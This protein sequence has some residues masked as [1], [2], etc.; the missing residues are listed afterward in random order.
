ML[1]RGPKLTSTR[2]AVLA[3]LA[4]MLEGRH[5]DCESLIGRFL[6]DPEYQQA[7]KILSNA[8]QVESYRRLARR[9][10]IPSPPGWLLPA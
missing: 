5:P 1:Q 4:L 3:E 9:D 6:R 7:T 10:E 8:I 2:E